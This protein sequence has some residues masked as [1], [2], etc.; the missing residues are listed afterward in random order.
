[1]RLLLVLLCSA[2][3]TSGCSDV[4]GA[5]SDLSRLLS[6]KDAPPISQPKRASRISSLSPIPL[7]APAKPAA[8]PG[9]G[10]K[11]SAAPGCP[12]VETAAYEAL[13]QPTGLPPAKPLIT[14]D[15]T[16]RWIEGLEG[17]VDTLKGHLRKTVTSLSTC[18]ARSP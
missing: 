11:L 12:D 3:M 1:M 10:T 15:D 18:H 14:P 9:T 4:R 6:I 8:G 13:E 7:T 16:K 5:Q 17:Q 2:L